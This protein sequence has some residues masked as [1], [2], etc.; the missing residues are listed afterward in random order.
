MTLVGTDVSE[1][2]SATLIREQ[3]PHGITTQDKLFS[4]FVIIFQ[5]SGL[6]PLTVN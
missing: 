3:E 6:I 2:L 4:E 1:E 5:P